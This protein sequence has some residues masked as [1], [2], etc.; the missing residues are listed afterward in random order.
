DITGTDQDDT[1]IGGSFDNVFQGRSGTNTF[2]AGDGK[3]NF[4]G[5][6]DKDTFIFEDFNEF[7]TSAT[8]IDKVDGCDGIDTL[9]F[10]DN[11]TVTTNDDAKIINDNAKLIEVLSLNR[12]TV[13]VAKITAVK[14]Y[15]IGGLV[16]NANVTVTGAT[17]SNK[18][19]V[20]TNGRTVDIS[21]AGQKVDL[22]LNAPVTGLTLLSTKGDADPLQTNTVTQLKADGN[23]NLTINTAGPTDRDL[24]LAAPTLTDGSVFTLNA[25]AFK[26]KLTAIGGAGNDSLT[27]GDGS[28]NLTGG[29]G[30]DIFR[31]TA[32]TDSNAGTLTG[33]DLTFD[34]ITDFTKGQDKIDVTGLGV[35]F[36]SVFNAQAAVNGTGQ[37]QLNSIVLTAVSTAINATELGYFVLGG[38]T[39]IL[40]DV[41]NDDAATGDDL[42]I[43]LSGFSAGLAITDFTV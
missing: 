39:Y 8:D 27:G 32:L 37:T 41:N 43:K 4:T 42:L 26:A 16:P 21:G 11:V 29:A 6:K 5:G 14:E 13:D 36:A 1:F 23:L 18:F 17:E 19:T 34:T 31:Y 2:T 15:E 12:G 10:T 35:V 28:D 38:N 40:S 24:V 7:N 33:A 30:N 25:S 20:L 3:N 9:Q 22:T